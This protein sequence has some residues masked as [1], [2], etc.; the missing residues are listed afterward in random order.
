MY[1]GTALREVRDASTALRKFQ[2]LAALLDRR[3]NMDPLK[4]SLALLIKLG[5]M[6]VH[7]EEMLSRKGHEFDKHALDTLTRDEE[8]VEW[9]A[10]MNKMAMLPLKR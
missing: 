7:Y 6:V 10:T 2:D 5:S 1:P 9:F 3:Q 4:P 8:V